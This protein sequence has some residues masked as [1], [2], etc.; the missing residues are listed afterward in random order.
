MQYTDAGL[1][2]IRP[3][4]VAYDYFYGLLCKWSIEES[5]GST[6]VLIYARA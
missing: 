2:S 6:E 1:R 5:L 4:L 3:F